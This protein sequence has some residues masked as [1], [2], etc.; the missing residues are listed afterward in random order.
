MTVA[1]DHEVVS[2]DLDMSWPLPSEANGYQ[3][4]KELRRLVRSATDGFRAKKE[5]VEVCFLVHSFRKLRSY[6]VSA[7]LGDR[8]VKTGEEINPGERQGEHREDDNEDGDEE[9]VEFAVMKPDANPGVY[10]HELLHMFGADD[11]YQV[12]SGMDQITKE[13][14]IQRSIMFNC[15]AIPLEKSVISALTA[16]NIGWK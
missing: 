2:P 7:H 5:E 16:Q 11:Y 10:A 3:K 9:V 6:A 12:L 14:F 8:P 15:G 1:F 13:R 4:L